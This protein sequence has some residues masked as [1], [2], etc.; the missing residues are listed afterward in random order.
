MNI[1]NINWYLKVITNLLTN[2][3]KNEKIFSI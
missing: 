1:L 2:E 3:I